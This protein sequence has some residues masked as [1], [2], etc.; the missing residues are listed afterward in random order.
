MLTA[1]SATATR[2]PALRNVLL[3]IL[4]GL[5]ALFLFFSGASKLFGA[6]MM[7]QLFGAVGVGQWFR[8][9]TGL[10]EVVGAVLL[11]VPRLI[12]V[13]ALLL[14]CV[15]AGAVVTHLF[16]IGGSP[17][18]PLFLLLALLFIARSRR[19]RLSHPLGMDVQG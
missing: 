9:V 1:Q 12:P 3:W 13:G 4:Q 11:V 15:M 14:S 8:Y 7:V 5:V 6:E 17:L 16:V 2:R 19:D 10:L 18:M